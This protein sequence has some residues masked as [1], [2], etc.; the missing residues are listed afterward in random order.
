MSILKLYCFYA[1]FVK[2]VIKIYPRYLPVNAYRGYEINRYNQFYILQTLK[3]SIYKFSG[4]Y[5]VNVNQKVYHATV[6]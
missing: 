3:S 6:N 2:F 4:L 5:F 1:L